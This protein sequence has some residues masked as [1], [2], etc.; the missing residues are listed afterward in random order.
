MNEMA[1]ARG[2]YPVTNRLEYMQAPAWFSRDGGG[3]KGKGNGG[4]KPR[5]FGKK[6]AATRWKKGTGKLNTGS[7]RSSASAPAASPPPNTSAHGATFQHGPRFKR[8]RFCAPHEVKMVEEIHQC[9][10]LGD[11]VD[12]P[13]GMGLDFERKC[14]M[15][16]SALVLRTVEQ[17]CLWLE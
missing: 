1:K 11:E 4:G 17:R 5:S 7:N 6:A 13:I 15:S 9:S 14:S 2:F 12:D 3:L 16:R 8:T 10:S